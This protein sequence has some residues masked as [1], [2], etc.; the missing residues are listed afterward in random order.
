M[1]KLFTKLTPA[2]SNTGTELGLY[3]C[4]NII[5]V[6]G[7]DIWAENNLD[8]K[9]Q[10]SGLHCQLQINVSLQFSKSIS[11]L[12]LVLLLKLINDI[13]KKVVVIYCFGGIGFG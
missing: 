10:H 2:D 9:E 4:K 12:N 7:G 1:S 3:I 11:F 5:K 13:K 8:E 6:H